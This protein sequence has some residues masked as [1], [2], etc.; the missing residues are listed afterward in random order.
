MGYEARYILNAVSKEK[1]DRIQVNEK[2]EWRP[3]GGGEELVLFA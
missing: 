1:T 3:Q 2:N